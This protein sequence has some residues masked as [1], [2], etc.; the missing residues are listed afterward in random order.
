VEVLGENRS[1]KV[2]NGRFADTF[3]PYGVHLYRIADARGQ[4]TR[5]PAA[6]RP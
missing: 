3:D 2:S 5:T 1:L 6:P 4:G